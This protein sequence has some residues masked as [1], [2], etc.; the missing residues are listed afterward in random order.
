M[1]DELPQQE[2]LVPGAEIEQK[3]GLFDRFKGARPALLGEPLKRP[4][5]GLS[6]GDQRFDHDGFFPCYI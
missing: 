4:T 6:L 5:Q 2:F 1:V 3:T